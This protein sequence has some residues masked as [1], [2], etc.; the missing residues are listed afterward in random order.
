MFTSPDYFRT[1][2]LFSAAIMTKSVYRYLLSSELNMS[3][4]SF[5]KAQRGGNHPLKQAI[6]H[7]LNLI[8]Y[9]FEKDIQNVVIKPNMCYYWDHTTGQTTDPN[10]VVALIDAIRDQVSPDVNVSIVES[11]ASAMR[12]RYAFKMLGYEKMAR[13]C[14]VA[15]INLS[16][17]DGERV[18]VI[19]GG[20]LFHFM[21][22]QTI[23]NADL[24]VNVPKIKYMGHTKITCA[25][26]NIYGCNLYQNKFKYH[27]KLAEAIVA[28]N[29]IMK[30]HLCVVDGNIVSGVQPRRLGLVMASRDPVALDVAAA[31]I[32]GVNAR[33]I[34]HIV[35]AGREG[36]GNPSFTPRGIGLDYFG[37][38]YP[39]KRVMNK[40][41]NLAYK[42]VRTLGLET[43]LSL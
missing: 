14:G 19:A 9:Q 40:L 35:L 11:D 23:R 27:P 4:V 41:M 28:L 34:R 30:F 31:K 26:K 33:S 10:F 12:C 1:K 37:S 16:E 18:E 17:D 36:I 43:R 32:A 29:K 38:R 22:P 20:Q 15:L 21:L 7:S 24:R 39:R 5:V 8:K 3:L 6:L 2:T 25:L 42:S 13:R